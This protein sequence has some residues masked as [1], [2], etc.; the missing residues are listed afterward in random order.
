MKNKVDDVLTE[1]VAARSAAGSAAGSA[2][3]SW[4]LGM[5]VVLC[6]LLV[7]FSPLALCSTRLVRFRPAKKLS[8]CKQTHARL[9]KGCIHE[10][11]GRFVFLTHT[12]V[13][14]A[15]QH[16]HTPHTLLWS[17]DLVYWHA[18]PAKNSYCCWTICKVPGFWKCLQSEMTCLVEFGEFLLSA[19][20]SRCWICFCA[21]VHVIEEA[22]TC[23]N[24]KVMTRHVSVQ[25]NHNQV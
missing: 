22:D 17:H 2:E 3:G 12:S 21:K 4:E 16:W 9:Q 6:V 24:T 5:A 20:A 19:F 15:S 8:I 18:S 1:S 23:W 14:P 25:V 13:D 7:L 11:S 10:L